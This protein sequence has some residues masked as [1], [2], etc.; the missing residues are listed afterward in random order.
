M[1]PAANTLGPAGCKPAHAGVLGRARISFNTS[2]PCVLGLLGFRSADQ[3]RA[4]G[5][6]HSRPGGRVTA[7]SDADETRAAYFANTPSA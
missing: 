5:R 2:A 3:D 7:P 1:L 6:E 4:Y